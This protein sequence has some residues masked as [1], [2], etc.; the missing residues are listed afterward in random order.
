[1]QVTINLDN[2]G[3][4]YTVREMRRR[5]ARLL[6]NLNGDQNVSFAFVARLDQYRPVDRPLFIEGINIAH[7]EL[8]RPEND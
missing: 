8:A 3:Q 4:P 2:H 5:L 7:G 6:S 1:M